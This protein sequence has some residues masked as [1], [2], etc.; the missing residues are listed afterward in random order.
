M[1]QLE[2]VANLLR[3][4][5][6]EAVVPEVE[7]PQEG[8]VSDER[9]YCSSQALARQVQDACSLGPSGADDPAPAAEV[10]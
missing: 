9:W 3:D 2:Q 7:G 8:E 10:G 4:F 5:A 1:S 6:V